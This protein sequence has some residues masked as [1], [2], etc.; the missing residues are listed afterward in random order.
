MASAGQSEG[1]GSKTVDNSQTKS[2]QTQVSTVRS[3]LAKWGQSLSAAV[4]WRRMLRFF[5]EHHAEVV[6]ILLH[7]LAVSAHLHPS[8]FNLYNAL[9]R[10]LK[11]PPLAHTGISL[12]VFNMKQFTHWSQILTVRRPCPTPAISLLRRARREEREKDEERKREEDGGNMFNAQGWQYGALRCH[13]TLAAALLQDKVKSITGVIWGWIKVTEM[14]ENKKSSEGFQWN[15]S[16][17]DSLLFENV[18]P[19]IVLTMKLLSSGKL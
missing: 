17:I 5:H 4:S 8:R 18:L 9:A 10:I 3:Q 12:S 14:L 11:S 2:G 7:F 13:H 1:A 6:T 16:A 15:V 19:C